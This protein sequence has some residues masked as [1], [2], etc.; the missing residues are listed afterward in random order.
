[1]RFFWKETPESRDHQGV[2][3]KILRRVKFTQ[4]LDVYV[5]SIIRAQSSQFLCLFFDFAGCHVCV[6]FLPRGNV[7]AR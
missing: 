2:R 4:S 1:M 6:H 7:A 3:C 5:P